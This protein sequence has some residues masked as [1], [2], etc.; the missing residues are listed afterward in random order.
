MP[1]KAVEHA[2]N[3]LKRKGKV[4]NFSPCIEQVQKTCRRMAEIGFY[5]IKTIEC[6]SRDL[7]VKSA[8]YKPICAKE[9]EDEA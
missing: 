9:Y 8:I 4:C 1:E 6:L 3:V 5:D 2:Y 7:N